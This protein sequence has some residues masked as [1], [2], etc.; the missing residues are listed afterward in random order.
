MKYLIDESFDRFPIGELPYDKFHTALGE[1]HH[2]IQEGYF[3]NWYDPIDIHQWRTMDGSWLVTYD[4]NG[5]YMEQNRGGAG[6]GAFK[7]VYATLANKEK[8]YATYGLDFSI[9]LFEIN[10]HYAGVAVSYI[11]SRKYYGIGINENGVAVFKRDNE[12]IEIIEKYDMEISDLTTYN[13]K[14]SVGDSLYVYLDNKVIIKAKI[15]FEIPSKIALVSKCLAR[16]SKLRVYMT[17]FEYKDHLKE[18]KLLG[19]SLDNKKKY[20]P[21]LKCINK[22]D[23][24][25]FGSGRQL[26]IAM[27]DNGPIFILA[28]HQKRYVRD[29]FAR[30]SSL[31]AFNYNGDV[32]WTIG[33]PCNKP[34]NTLISCDLPF[35][36]ADINNDGRLEVIY[37]MDFEVRIID[38][39]TAKPIKSMPTPI[40]KGDP[41]VKDEPFYRLNVD[42]IRVADFEGLGYKGDFIIKDRYQNVWAYNQNMELMWRYHNKNTGHFP[43][44]F[45]YN[46]DGKDE[47]FVGYDLVDSNGN[48]IF[49]LPM[50]SDHT[51]EIIYAK[52]NEEDGYK[53]VLA[54]GNEGLNIINNDGTIFKHNEIGHAQRISVAPY[55]STTK[56]LSIIASAFWGSFG[57]VGSYNSKGE[58]HKIM[59]ME[60]VGA[61]LSPINYDGYHVFALTHAGKDGGLIDY[62]LDTVVEFPDDGHPTLCQEVFDIDNDGID[63]IICWD[64]NSMWFYKAEKFSMG[65]KYEKYP[66]DAF[67]N[68]RGEYLIPKE[69]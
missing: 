33:K 45:D 16:Y 51:D 27:T 50:N 60:S 18:Q 4:E 12:N 49:D 30:I 21:K 35:Q 24:K 3:G 66:D 13:F 1:Y 53:F 48:I 55:D 25:D 14:I 57:I 32:L 11:T 63:E 15:K 26:R 10:E 62:D 36:I 37:S 56:D 43:Y 64:L 20:L 6:T 40:I 23:L 68:Y 58:L 41:L 9:R 44:I 61:I 7:N 38:L 67:S 69:E 29:S 31:T 22:I 39:L 8:L 47:M 17:D 42:A 46:N 19:K 52:L 5:Y 54:S 34:D 2:I 59:E 65:K 28:Q